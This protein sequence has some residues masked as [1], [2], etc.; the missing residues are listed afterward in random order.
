MITNLR[1]K[2]LGKRFYGFKFPTIVI[3][4]MFKQRCS[5][6]SSGTEERISISGLPWR[7]EGVAARVIVGEGAATKSRQVHRVRCDVAHLG[8]LKHGTT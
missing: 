5:K 3:S 6:T 2:Y 4:T 7:V 8:D 1:F